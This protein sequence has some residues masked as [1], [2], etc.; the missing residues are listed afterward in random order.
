MPIVSSLGPLDMYIDKQEGVALKADNGNFL[1]CI[2]TN[3]SMYLEPAKANKDQ[4]CK[5]QVSKCPDG[6]VLL[7][8]P[9][10]KYLSRYDEGGIQYIRPVKSSPDDY[11]KFSVFTDNNKI[12]LRAD[13]GL[14]VSRIQR[15]RQN[16][17]AAK[18]GPDECCKYDVSIG[19]V[20]EPS[21][22]ILSIEVKDFQPDKIKT[23][24]AVTEQ[25]YTNN[26]SI[27]QSHTFKLSWT[28]R[29]SETTTWNH[30]WGFSSTLSFDVLFVKCSATVS[31]NGSYQKSST[32]EKTI[33]VAD[34]TTITV[35]SKK[36]VVAQ[37][38][39]NKNDNAVV[40][41][42]AKIKKIDCNGTETI[43]TEEGTWKGILYTNVTI[44]A[45]E[46]PI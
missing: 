8:D 29:T 19:D 21:F 6:K 22:T 9:R 18:E 13:N 43:L 17:E 7:K 14:Y 42:R 5:F 4:W 24:T 44:D 46:Q 27:N 36:K 11:C 2:G 3:E 20:V 40:P 15:E 37:L 25:A 10:G 31:Y 28:D 41:F 32:L 30:A 45:S 12:L 26:T 34:E 16:I 23:P 38:I 35:P 1:S 33:T 39:V